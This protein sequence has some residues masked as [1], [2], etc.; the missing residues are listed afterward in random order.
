MSSLTGLTE[1]EDLSL[2]LQ[3]RVREYDPSIDATTGSQFY[4]KVIL[5]LIS[6]LG[7]DPY[8]TPIK[9]FIIGRLAVEYP[10]MVLQD[11]EPVDDLIV[12]PMQILLEPYRRQIQQVSNN[13]SLADPTILNEREADNLGANYFVRRRP[14][15]FSVGVARLYYSAPQGAVVTPNNAV[16][17]SAGHRFFPVE[18]QAISSGNMLFNTEDN[19]YFFDV[20][21]RSEQEGEGYNIPANTLVGIEEL[22]SVV[23]VTNRTQFEEG[24]DKE[25]TTEYLERVEN[26][27]TEKSLVTF[28][29][30][31]SRLLEVFDNIRLIQVIGYGDPE[32]NRD[33]LTGESSEPTPYAFFLGDTGSG[34]PQI[35]LTNATDSILTP[36]GSQL[37]T[38]VESYTVIGDIVV[39]ANPTTGDVYR[40]EVTAVALQALQ[41][42]PDVVGDLSA[43]TFLISHAS[44]SITVSGIP[45]G[46]LQPETPAGTIEVVPNEVHLGGMMDVFV[47]AGSP[48]QRDM[49]LEG[50]LDGEPLHFGLDL[51]SFGGREDE[52][53]QVTERRD[54]QALRPSID[55][56]GDPATDHLLICQY[57]DI[58]EPA[59]PYVPWKP[60]EDDIGRYIQILDGGPQGTLEILEILSDEYYSGSGS[61]IRVVRIKVSLTNVENPAV[62]YTLGSDDTTFDV[63]FRI[64]EKVGVKN[65]VRDRDGS[66]LA[67]TTP[68]ILSGIDFDALG[69]N[70]GDSVVIEM[71]DD[72]GIYTIRKIL[73]SLNTYDTLL[74]DRDLTTTTVPTGTGDHSGLRYRIA[75]ELNVDLVEPKIVKIPLGTIFTGDDLSTVAASDLVSATGTTNFLLAGVEAGDTLE[76]TEGDDKGS[77]LLKS[78]SGTTAVLDQTLLN[79]AT[80]LDFT[81]YRSVDGIERPMVRVKEVEL[82]DSNSQPTGIKIPYGNNIDARALGVFSNR[83]EGSQQESYTG[84]TQADTSPPYLNIRLYDASVDFVSEGVVAGYRLNIFNTD[85]AGYYTI[86][87]V[88]TGDGLPSHHYIEVAVPADGGTVWAELT[89]NVH[90][91]VG[92]PSS[93]VAR[94]YFQEPTSVEIVTGLSG[95]RLSFDDAG[96]PKLFHFSVVDGFQVQPTEEDSSRSIRVVANYETTTPDSFETILEFTD[97]T[98]PNVLNSEIRVGDVLEVNDQIPFRRTGGDSFAEIGIFGRP[99]GLSTVAGSN[100]VTVPQTSLIDFTAMNSSYP[101]VG[102]SL[103][104]DEGA[105]TGKYIIEEVV[106]SKTLRLDKVMTSSTETIILYESATPRDA[107]LIPGTSSITMEDTTDNP[108][109]QIGNYITIFESTRGDL[110]G[111]FEIKSIPGTNQVELDMDPLA[112]ISTHSPRVYFLGLTP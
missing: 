10:E 22:A 95:G 100:R 30:I 5:P 53:V 37:D 66:R 6:R 34:G 4:N 15:G 48:V 9:S 98:G 18:N 17:D 49:I 1:L 39:Y 85:N 109:T 96:T 80:H 77:Y 75:D 36:D 27:L 57:E 68:D 11:G 88:G 38:F 45:G 83:A 103:Y 92:V 35:D 91:T 107:T 108:G 93:G 76:I 84:A 24:A 71:G 112:G 90:Y 21:V 105:D 101:L 110:D 40:H 72:A 42:T 70:V 82:L 33:I 104:I 12:R 52:Y 44:A 19:L 26:S 73:G 106:N 65:R 61:L 51:E 3:E 64:V 46:I 60:T 54:G 50:V 63:D 81:I 59:D 23:K 79:T 87:K 31:N 8:N 78:V 20:V 14:G 97:T 43:S 56:F 89:T 41:V 55:R 32:M 13:Q 69:A 86:A 28:R 67:Y 2:F 58:T 94:I 25:T 29:G 99:A 7:P 62:T 111:V 16:Y 74:L 102:Q 47:R